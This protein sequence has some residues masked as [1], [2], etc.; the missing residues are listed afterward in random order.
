MQR[1]PLGRK[2]DMGQGVPLSA[3]GLLASRVSVSIPKPYGF[4]SLRVDTFIHAGGLMH[5]L[6]I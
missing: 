3:F 5:T 4:A 1:S 6:S 2:A